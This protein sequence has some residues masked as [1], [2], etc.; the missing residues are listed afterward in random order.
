MDSD[1]IAA[2]NVSVI[3]ATHNRPTMLIR[4]VESVT[5]QISP[6]GEIVIIN[7]GSDTSY[8][9]SL[10][11]IKRGLQPDIELIYER[12]STSGGAAKARNIG[13]KE[14]SGSIIMFLDDDDRW[15]PEKIANQIQIF[16]NNPGV[17]MVYSGRIVVNE[18]GEEL[19]KITPQYQ[20]DIYRTLL[21]KNVIGVTS[22]VAMRRS[23]FEQADGFDPKMPARQDYD[24]WIRAAKHTQI[25]YDPSATVEWSTQIERGA[26]MSSRPDLYR[27]A[28][29]RF[30][31]K[32]AK[33][34]DQL[35][36]YQRR[37]AYATQYSTLAEKYSHS[38]S[39][40][41]Y[42]YAIRSLLYYP[43]ASALVNLLPRSIDLKLRKLVR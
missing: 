5:Q 21:E 39:S 6:P 16:Q 22:S 13:V 11:E 30:F 26:Q 10:E 42:R 34:L 28:V 43:S 18:K 29:Q 41:K 9:R 40:K 19:Y 24:L 38:K 37:R 17:G 20:G 33:E 32:Y 27:D 4:A 2:S 1:S 3:I 25:G 35:P 7:D 23:L 36:W 14:S 31:T 15:R 12:L 8:K